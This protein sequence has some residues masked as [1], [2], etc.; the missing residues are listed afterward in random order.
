MS[1][2]EGGCLLGA[3]RDTARGE[4]IACGFTFT[5]V[6]GTSLDDPGRRADREKVRPARG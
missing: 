2:D 1:D 4:P 3:V 6:T 5:V